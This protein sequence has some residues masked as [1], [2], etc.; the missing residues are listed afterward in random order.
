MRSRMALGL[1]VVGVVGV[2]AAMMVLVSCGGSVAWLGGIQ[3]LYGSAW[4]RVW[5]IPSN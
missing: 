3:T 2:V 4:C 1:I 5:W